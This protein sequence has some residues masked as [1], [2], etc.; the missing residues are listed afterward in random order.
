MKKIKIS[1][2]ILVSIIL[3][4]I[5]LLVIT[6]FSN[7]KKNAL[8]N[9]NYT[10][11]ISPYSNNVVC[12]L[13]LSTVMELNNNYLSGKVDVDDESVNLT[14]VN[15]NTESPSMIGNL[16]DRTNLLKIDNGS[17]LYLLEK[18]DFG[19]LNIFTIFRNKN[20]IL[21]SKQYSVF[22][23]SPFGLMMIG[24]CLSGV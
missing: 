14:F 24:D 5:V 21:M 9:K 6:S 16:G 15:L 22:G 1:I 7:D 23:E 18:T 4:L 20:I 10:E 2:F 11:S 3:V 13:K 12:T 17:T 8:L 19:N